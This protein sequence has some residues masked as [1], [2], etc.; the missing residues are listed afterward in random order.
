MY[1]R[2]Y[3]WERKEQWEPLWADIQDKAEEVLQGTVRNYSHY[4]GALILSEG[5]AKH[6]QVPIKQVIDGQQRITTLELV[7]NALYRTATE[8]GEIKQAAFLE[9][10]ILNEKPHLMDDPTVEKHKLWPTKYDRELYTD[11]VTQSFPALCDKYYRFYYKNGKLISNQAPRLLGALYYFYESIQTF[12]DEEDSEGWERRLS[13]LSEALLDHFSIVVIAIDDDDDAQTIFSTLNARGKP[14]SAMDL[15]RND[16]F[17]RAISTQ[18]NAETLFDTKWKEFEDP[19][20]D[21]PEVQGRLTRKRIESFLGSVLAAERGETINLSKLYPE[22]RTYAYGAQYKTVDSEL[23]RLLSYAPPYRGLKNPDT[24]QPLGHIARHLADWDM[25]TAFPLIMSVEIEMKSQQDEARELYRTLE[26]YTIRRAYCGLGAKAYNNL[27]LSAIKFLRE[28]GW[29]AENFGAFLLSQ[30]GDSSRF[31]TDAEFQT[32]IVSQPIYKPGWE[33][34][35]RV[36]LQALEQ[37]LR[38]TK[39]DVIT[40]QAGFTVE[41]VMPS[42]WAEHWPLSTGKYSPTEDIYTA[43]VVHKLDDVTAEAIRQ[44]EGL[45][46]TLGNLTLVTQPLNSAISHGPFALKQAEL[47]RSAL[48]LNRMIAEQPVWSEDQIKARSL[49]LAH[50]ASVYWARPSFDS[51]HA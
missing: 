7:I 24:S 34:R 42:K 46:N 50:N 40:I 5:K 35:A 43:L 33:R 1:Q 3:E 27:F 36:I 51:E 38:T 11:V 10:H 20:W 41:H 45:K 15:I 8:R 17:Q 19:F 14:L 22:Y 21:A 2:H 30:T 32:A 6:G 13:A 47:R 48:L 12:I 23:S 31:P 37:T 18:E 49:K 39:D 16:I 28:N 4:M 44:R 29:T 26:A 9:S 25:T